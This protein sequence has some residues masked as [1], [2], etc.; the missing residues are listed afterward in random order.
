MKQKSTEPTSET[1]SADWLRLEEVI[2]YSGMSVNAFALHI[3]LLRSE[4]LYQIKKGI[5][6]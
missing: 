3:G 2:N 6:A 5:T 4:N 1:K